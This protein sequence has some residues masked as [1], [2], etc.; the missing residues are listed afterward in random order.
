[1]MTKKIVFVVVLVGFLA[2]VYAN[3]NAKDL[4]ME[5]IENQ[6][7]EKTNIEKMAKCDNRN[8]MQFFGLDYEQYESHIFYKGKEALSVEEILI[9]K[10]HSEDDL[11]SVKDAVD[12]RIA[13]QIK[14]F[15]GY[16]PEQVA[17]LKNAIVTT[18][19]NYLFYCVSKNPEKYEEVFKDAI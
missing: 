3:G 6:L 2:M 11:A 9:V 7:K 12:T 17:M 10:A 13:S 14:T 19:G 18:K 5:D 16:G 1:M 8:L 15:E 4:P